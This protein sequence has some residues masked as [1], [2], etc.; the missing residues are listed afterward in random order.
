MKSQKI[1]VVK[2]DVDNSDS[3]SDDMGPKLIRNSSSME[4]HTQ[5]PIFLY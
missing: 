4:G 2:N 3:D 5:K 1:T